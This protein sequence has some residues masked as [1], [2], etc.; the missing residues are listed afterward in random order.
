MKNIHVHFIPKGD[1]ELLGWVTNYDNK[2]SVVGPTLGFTPA[3]ITDQ[4]DK[5]QAVVTALNNLIQKTREKEEAVTIKNLVRKNE[6]QFLADTA[7]AMKRNPLFTE[8]IG[9]VLGIMPS[10]IP[11]LKTTLQP[12]IKL[13]AYPGVIEVSFNKRAQSAVFIFSRVQGT[14]AWTMLVNT[15]KSPYRDTRQA[16]VAGKPEIREY[17]AQCWDGSELI[18]QKCDVASIAF[19]E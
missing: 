8:S 9:D 14:E 11:T 15:A 17:C 4:K 10:T 16:V 2:I 19:A 7:I 13:N 3:A 5:A 6:V 1:P 12:A 18:G